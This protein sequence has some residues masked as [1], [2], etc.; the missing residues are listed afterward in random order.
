MVMSAFTLAL[1]QGRNRQERVLGD[2]GMYRRLWSGFLGLL[3]PLFPFQ[4]R[5][6][7]WQHP[8]KPWGPEGLFP[9][10]QP[11]RWVQRED[12]R[13]SCLLLVPAPGAGTGALHP[14]PPPPP[15][16]GLAPSTGDLGFKEQAAA[17]APAYPPG[18]E[19]GELW[20]SPRTIAGEMVGLGHR[21]DPLRGAM[22]LGDWDNGAPW[23]A[24]R[25][26][27]LHKGY[28]VPLGSDMVLKG[29]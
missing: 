15:L 27:P 18:E 1:L 6:R 22:V 10:G 20:Q 8:R 7:G 13:H 4:C 2:I 17:R 26:L 3:A 25:S 16:A 9:S 14:L 21:A 11:G 24:V 28:R 19:E 5:Q 23:E 12:T 29:K